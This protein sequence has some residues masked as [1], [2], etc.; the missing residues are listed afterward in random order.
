MFH[1]QKN[2][3][4]KSFKELSKCTVHCTWL[5]W[6]CFEKPKMLHSFKK[7]HYFQCLASEICWVLSEVYFFSFLVN[8]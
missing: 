7:Y 8:Q 5:T 6:K 1:L 3:L 2:L 4:S